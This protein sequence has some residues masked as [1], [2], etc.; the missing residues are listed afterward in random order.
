M[1][2][3]IDGLP[4]SVLALEAIGKV[5]ADD[6]RQVLVPAIED[7]LARF[8]KVRLL[9]VLGRE[10]DGFSGGAAW[11]DT[12]LGMSHFTAFE[13]VAVVTD[14]DWIEAMVKA[15]GFA[16]PGE[17]ATFDVD[18][19]EEARAWIAAAQPPGKLEFELDE[20]AGVLVLRPHDELEAGDFERVAAAVDPYLDKAGRLSGVM[21][22]ADEFPGWDSFAAMTSHFRFVREHQDKVR[23]VALVTSSRFLSALPRLAKRFI[24]AEVRHFDTGQIDEARAWVSG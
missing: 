2:K 3:L 14:V 13:R 24:D 23:R 22:V 1:L 19:L 4:D 12:K 9:Y 7:R 17:V 8:P 5:T 16:L 11:E 6:Y 20:N 21:I 15:I 18:E 10:F